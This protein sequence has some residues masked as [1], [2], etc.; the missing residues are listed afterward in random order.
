MAKIKLGARPKSF[1]STVKFLMLD[2][3]E[4][5]IECAYRYRTRTEFGVFIDGL[6]AS[7]DGASALVDGK[8][9]M[10]RMMEQTTGS[11]ADFVMKALEGWNLD[12]EFSPATVQQLSDELPAAMV[13]IM[14]T[15]RTACV[16]GRLG[17][18]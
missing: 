18:F 1:K 10:A 16:E 3:S 8:F 4:G 11:N 14:E 7:D 17:N 5:I 13:A 9:S 6:I 12:E 15:Y 2:G